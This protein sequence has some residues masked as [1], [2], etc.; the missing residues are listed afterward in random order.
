[1][2]IDDVVYGSIRYGMMLFLAETQMHTTKK[3]GNLRSILKYLSTKTIDELAAAI[4]DIVKKYPETKTSMI[5]SLTGDCFN[6]L[7]IVIPNDDIEKAI[8]DHNY[9]TYKNWDDSVD[10]IEQYELSVFP[11]MIRM[12][13]LNLFKEVDDIFECVAED[14]QTV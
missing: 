14:N 5:I 7:H 12:I 11:N 8:K 1:M 4:R 9:N 6:V 2:E 13:I 10:P 3:D